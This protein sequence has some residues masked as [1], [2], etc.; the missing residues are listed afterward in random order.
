MSE[1]EIVK[2]IDVSKVISEEG[3]P[4]N[5]LLLETPIPKTFMDAIFGRNETNNS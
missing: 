2:V 4:F 3:Y 5:P 1:F